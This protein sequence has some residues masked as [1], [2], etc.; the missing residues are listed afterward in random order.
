MSVKGV[1]TGCCAGL[2][3][4]LFP[5]APA[6]RALERYPP[7][8]FLCAYMVL[9]HPGGRG[10]R[11]IQ[12]VSH[13]QQKN[14]DAQQPQVQS[15]TL[16]LSAGL[17]ACACFLPSSLLAEVVFNSRGEREAA[18]TAAGGDMLRAFETLLAR[19][20]EGPPA[21]AAGATFSA[22]AEQQQDTA[23]QREEPRMAA[24]LGAL[25]QVGR[26]PCDCCSSCSLL[27]HCLSAAFN[28]ICAITRMCPMFCPT[29]LRC[30]AL[31]RPGWPTWS[32]LWPGSRQTQ[33]RSQSCW[34]VPCIMDGVEECWGP[35][36]F[37]PSNHDVHPPF[38][39]VCAAG[40]ETELIR[41]AVDLESSRLAKVAVA[42][43]GPSRAALAGRLRSPEDL[44]VRLALGSG[45]HH[46]HAA[47]LPAYL[48]LVCCRLS[49]CLG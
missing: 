49:G 13:T 18:L 21:G 16:C 40:L 15:H 37:K 38:R 7:R 48:S 32:S 44:Q 46:L 41:V 29:Q 47:W 5:R 8:I 43:T 9:A 31:T 39:E 45:R 22:N 1:T 19:L 23:L 42:P 14:I 28:R 20:A 34:V 11:A 25:L 4:R 26:C 12:R 30:S 6:G 2:L 10:G 35:M 27:T 17:C 24:P 36:G 33:V 3:R